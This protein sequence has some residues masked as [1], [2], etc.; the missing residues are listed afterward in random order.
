MTLRIVR[1]Q[2]AFPDNVTKSI[3]LLGPIPRT[4][5]TMFLTWKFEAHQLLEELGYDGVVFD[6][7]H[8][9]VLDGSRVNYNKRPQIDWEVEAMR[10]ADVIV[11]W[12]P[13]QFPSMPAMTSNIEMGEFFKS[14][15][16]ILG[17]PKDTRRMEYI[18]YRATEWL[19][20]IYKWQVPVYNDLKQTL[21]VTID[22]I[23]EGALRS[24]TET[25]IPL[26]VWQDTTFQQWY[27]QLKSAGHALEDFNVEYVFCRQQKKNGQPK[28][29]LWAMRPKV[30]IVREA[31]FKDNEVVICRPAVVSVL[32]YHKS[33]H[34]V[35]DWDIVLVKEYRPAVM[36]Y[37]GLVYELPGG[38]I[39]PLEGPFT[40]PVILNSARTEVFEEVGLDIDPIRLCELDV[41][42]SMATMVACEH[43]LYTYEL[44][45]GEFRELANTISNDGIPIE[46]NDEHTMPVVTKIGE[47][48]ATHSQLPVDWVNMGMIM[49]FVALQSV[50]KPF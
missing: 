2:E 7:E 42:Q 23:G 3:F 48:M 26:S 37:K 11:A 10:R 5:D 6:P 4:E 31:R 14:G 30:R 38:S 19:K 22:W 49:K 15:K 34:D 1:G 9:N 18:D 50:Y 43:H 8:E 12:I 36:N 13:R 29:R 33:G 46:D 24:G 45:L 28:I 27:S 35:K 17:Y 40:E 32:M 47:V 39:E 20:K 44:N 41:R 25:K 16:M 21:S